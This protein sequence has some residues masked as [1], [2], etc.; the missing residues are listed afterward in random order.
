M[1][2]NY[3][4]QTL[5][6]RFL[7]SSCRTKSWDNPIEGNVLRQGNKKCVLPFTYKGKEYRKCVSSSIKLSESFFWCP[8][9]VSTGGIYHPDSN[10]RGVCS[11]KCPKEGTFFK[12]FY[13][14]NIKICK[15]YYGG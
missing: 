5:N 13:F 6:F 3:V 14:K 4:G 2:P 12:T 9:E 15:N 7:D 11:D 8:T 10:E 1:N